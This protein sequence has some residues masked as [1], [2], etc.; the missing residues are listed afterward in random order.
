MNPEFLG[1]KRRNCMKKKVL[2]L[3]LFAFTIGVCFAQN[4]ANERRIVG[5]WVDTNG[6]TWVFNANGNLTYKGVVFK[7]GV[8]VTQLA[9]LEDNSDL[10]IY[11]ISISS[12]GVTIILIRKHD[13]TDSLPGDACL[14]LTKK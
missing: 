14:W 1:R 2:V 8:T 9:I 13:D 6:Q 7:Y 10:A 4:T 3:V 11:D 12:D 5:T